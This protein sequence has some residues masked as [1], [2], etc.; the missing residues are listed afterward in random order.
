MFV[1][2][3][4]FIERLIARDFSDFRFYEQTGFPDS[5]DL[6]RYGQVALEVRVVIVWGMSVDVFRYHCKVELS[7]V[8]ILG[9]FVCF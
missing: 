3:R 1:N 9:L 5:S 2:S 4:L 8:G 7:L 6:F